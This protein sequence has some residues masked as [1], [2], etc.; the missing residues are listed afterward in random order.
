MKITKQQIKNVRNN[1]RIITNGMKYRIEKQKVCG[2]L[3][4]KKKKWIQLC[5]GNDDNISCILDFPAKEDAIKTMGFCI[6][7][8]LAQ[9]RG[10]EEV[11]Q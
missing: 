11:K 5:R 6:K 10:W 7:E 4:W 1:Y 9:I 2:M 3:R 8:D